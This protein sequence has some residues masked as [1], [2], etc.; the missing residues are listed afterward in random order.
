MKKLASLAIQNEP[1]EDSDLTARMRR[2][3]WIFAGRTCPKVRLLTLQ[4]VKIWYF[5][6]RHSWYIP[7]DTFVIMQKRGNRFCIRLTFSTLG[8]NFSRQHFF[9]EN[10]VFLENIKWHTFVVCWISAES[11]KGYYYRQLLLVCPE[12]FIICVV[13][14]ID[15]IFKIVWKF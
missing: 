1:S 8:K 6:F 13:F 5:S 11:G 2:L 12:R 3:I 9:P 14:S 10:P 15:C 4:L 7:L